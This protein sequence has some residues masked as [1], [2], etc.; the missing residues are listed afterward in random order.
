MRPFLYIFNYILYIFKALASL[1][2]P[3]GFEFYQVQNVSLSSTK[4]QFI[5][6]KMSVYQ[7]Q[8]VSLSRLIFF[9]V[10]L[11]QKRY[12]KDNK[13]ERSLYDE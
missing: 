13:K 7:V 3:R 4:C 2:A 5:K 10:F 9:V 1:R 8:N 12:Y 6:Y 11:K